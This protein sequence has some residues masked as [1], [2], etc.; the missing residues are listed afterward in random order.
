MGPVHRHP[1]TKVNA[2]DWMWETTKEAWRTYVSLVD[3]NVQIKGSHLEQLKN[4]ALV[5]R[6][7]FEML[8]DVGLARLFSR[9]ELHA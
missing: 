9:C 1:S 4:N 3:K 2:K 6:L 8:E 5:A 7:L